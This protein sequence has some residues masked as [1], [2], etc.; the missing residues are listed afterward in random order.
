MN[1]KLQLDKGKLQRLTESV[2]DY[3]QKGNL[4][5]AT[6]YNIIYNEIITIF[7]VHSESDQSKKDL[8]NLSLRLGKFILSN[9]KSIIK[10][11]VGI[12]SALTAVSGLSIIGFMIPVSGWLKKKSER[13]VKHEFY[14]NFIQYA[15]EELG[16][17]P[18]VGKENNDPYSLTKE[19]VQ[20]NN[21]LQ[22]TDMPFVSKIVK[23]PVLRGEDLYNKVRDNVVEITT[24][25][26]LVSGVFYSNDGL[27]VT[28]R[29]VIQGT[30]QVIVR[31]F[32]SEEFHGQ[33][34]LSFRDID[35]AFVQVN[36]LKKQIKA[37]LME[38]NISPGETVYAIGSPRAFSHSLTKGVVS[39]SGRIVGKVKYIQHDAAIN[40]GNSGGPLF[41]S[42]GILIGI[43]TWGVIDSEGMGFAIP[44]S[45]VSQK[46][47]QYE[48]IL[49]N[50][51]NRNYCIVCGESSKENARYCN[52]CGS[53]LNKSKSSMGHSGLGFDIVSKCTCGQ[54]R[55]DSEKYC[56]RCGKSLLV[57]R[58]D[59]N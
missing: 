55:I 49:F 31:G 18:D 13:A 21:Q 36:D 9:Y 28:N 3:I 15:D 44:I 59:V 16:N 26:G 47:K 2:W 17:T 42:R 24:E 43:N 40:G 11:K 45:Y 20:V 8:R 5:P 54:K 6:L 37:P 50:N 19:I 51:H 35:I 23:A 38:E 29:H 46:F 39:S 4:H 58:S 25:Y 1:N 56:D 14:E 34:L 22:N 57:E 33:V 41:N 53:P 12:Y 10:E 30:S 27:I 52:K 48:N 32:N 7:P